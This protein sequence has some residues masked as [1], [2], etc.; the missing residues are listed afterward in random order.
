MIKLELPEIVKKMAIQKEL[1]VP[2][3]VGTVG[4]LLEHIMNENPGL[5]SYLYDD[6]RNI[7]LCFR[8]YVNRKNIM[9]LK[10]VDTKLSDKDIVRVVAAIAGG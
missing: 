4:K 9:S 6:N 1:M 3:T 5:E 7:R 8:L 2:D 10:G